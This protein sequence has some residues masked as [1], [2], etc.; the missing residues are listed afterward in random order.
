MEAECDRLA[1]TILARRRLQPDK[2]YLVAIA[3]VPG[4]GKTTTA[5]AVVNCLNKI[6]P[7]S[8]ATLISMD[9]FHLSRAILDT[10]P[11]RDEV[12]LRRGA[13]WTF[14]ASSLLLFTRRL[15]EWANS[16][17][18]AKDCTPQFLTAPGF[19]HETK[20]P[21]Q[22]AT[23]ITNDTQ[24]VIFEGNYLL[25]DKPQWREI[26]E[27]VDY[28]VFVNVDTQEARKRLAKRH[29]EA[30]IETSLEDAFRRVDRNDS[31]NGLLI[32]EN[33]IAPDTVI[34]SIADTAVEY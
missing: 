6:N 19:S 29:V 27:L 34:S 11:N 1:K 31:L 8:K 4:S 9:G 26:A 28:R 32:L 3:G 25:L 22:D 14:D 24:V 5:T 20:D 7:A 18:L 30:G 13:P 33:M 23:I 15:R 21:I 12:Y 17:P 10:L 2:R 16:S